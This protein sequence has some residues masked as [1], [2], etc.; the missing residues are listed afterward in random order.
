MTVFNWVIRPV[1]EEM[2]EAV[3]DGLSRHCTYWQS[4]MLHWFELPISSAMALET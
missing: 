3:D 2:K 1:Y 4:R